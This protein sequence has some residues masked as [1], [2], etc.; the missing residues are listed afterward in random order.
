[1][2]YILCSMPYSPLAPAPLALPPPPPAATADSSHTA[3]KLAVS[4]T[5][6]LACRLGV[7]LEPS[8]RHFLDPA[9]DGVVGLV[10]IHIDHH[11]RQ[12]VVLR[13]L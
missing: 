10:Q 2:L 13:S 7:G 1:M 6:G 12:P 11:Q 8:Q 3:L 5:S 4:R 9:I